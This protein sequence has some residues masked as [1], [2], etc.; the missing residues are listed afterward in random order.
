MN[1]LEYLL[2]RAKELGVKH[3]YPVKLDIRWVNAED[4][5]NIRSDPTNARPNVIGAL[6]YGRQ[7]TVLDE[8]GYWARID[9][10]WVYAPYLTPL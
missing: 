5:L 6:P 7:V 10:G 3:N 1:T 4:G 2:T 9:K 8:I